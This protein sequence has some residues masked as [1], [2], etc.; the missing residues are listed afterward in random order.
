M[1]E[2]ELIALALVGVFT[3]ALVV[4]VPLLYSRLYVKVDC[5]HVLIVTRLPEIHVYF[6]GGVVIPIVHRAETMDITV[7]V[8]SIDRRG[9]EGIHCRDDIRADLQ[10]KFFV[11]VRKT[12]DDVLRVAQTIGAERASRLETLEELFVAKLAEAIKIVAKQL[13]FEELHARRDEFKQRILETI[14]EDL[15]GYVVDDLAIDYLEQ[16]PVEHLDGNNILDARGLRAITEIT[17]PLEIR[18][19]ELL[20]EKAQRLAELGLQAKQQL[21]EIEHQQA[22]ALARLRTETG[23]A[24][25]VEQLEDRLTTRLREMV[26]LVVKEH[27]ERRRPPERVDPPREAQAEPTS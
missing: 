5:G 13:D 21:I 27:D 19:Q 6:S 14:G 23:R 15:D 18:T 24:L 17:A 10:A 8:L 2:A 1:K 22:T 26:E 3:L 25:T 12:A 11:R 4:G 7:K 16:T 9:K 20:H